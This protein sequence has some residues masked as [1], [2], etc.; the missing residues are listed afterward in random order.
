[1]LVTGHQESKNHFNISQQLKNHVEYYNY[2]YPLFD[3][4]DWNNKRI[5][6]IGM[7]LTAIDTLLYYTEN[8]EEVNLLEQNGKTKYSPSGN[9]PK[10]LYALSRSGHFCIIVRPHNQKEVDL[11]KYEHKGYFYT[12]K[13]AD[14]M[15][16]NLGIPSHSEKF[17]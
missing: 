13:L 14:T 12:R 10:K 17:T 5:S 3:I 11:D 2:A 9:E 16:E 15:R 6:V 7:G 8:K 4:P 1:M